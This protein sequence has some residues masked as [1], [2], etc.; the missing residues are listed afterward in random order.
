MVG[1]ASATRKGLV[2]LAGLLPRTH[3]RPLSH[4]RLTRGLLAA[5]SPPWPDP[6]LLS[7]P[8]PPGL[9]RACML[10]PASARTS[11]QRGPRG[12]GAPD[13]ESSPLPTSK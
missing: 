2:I 4:R 11:S 7:E 6:P 3:C 13:L 9:P 12:T 5:G 8:A 10:M 1:S